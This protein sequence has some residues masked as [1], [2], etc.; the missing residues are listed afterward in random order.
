[1]VYLLRK[2]IKLA[3]ITQKLVTLLTKL[4]PTEE[5]RLILKCFAKPSAVFKTINRTKFIEDEITKDVAYLSGAVQDEKNF[6]IKKI[7][8]LPPVTMTGNIKD[9]RR[10]PKMYMVLQF[11]PENNKSRV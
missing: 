4:R 7:K 6:D 11:M 2:K 9:T 5:D 3:N 8:L 1:M 10:K